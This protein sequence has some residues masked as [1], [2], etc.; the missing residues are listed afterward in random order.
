[1]SPTQQQPRSLQA[2]PNWQYAN[3]GALVRLLA[4]TAECAAQLLSHPYQRNRATPNRMSLLRECIAFTRS[5]AEGCT[6]EASVGLE[7]RANAEESA[8]DCL[9]SDSD[10]AFLGGQLHEA[11]D[12]VTCARRAVEGAMA[13]AG[14]DRQG[15][16]WAVCEAL[17]AA[18][19]APTSAAGQHKMVQDLV[20][21][22]QALG[23][24]SL[25]PGSGPSRTSPAPAARRDRSVTRGRS[26]SNAGLCEPSLP[27]STAN[28]IK[29]RKRS[30]NSR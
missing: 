13:A 1:M 3:T 2:F 27:T 24:A 11:Y 7:L 23:L 9:D 15:L 18:E 19:T 8:G 10:L 6:V 14:N 21:K 26:T 20:A 12:V 30:G 25:K 17:R 16:E 29:R 5:V 22:A 28:S 4:E